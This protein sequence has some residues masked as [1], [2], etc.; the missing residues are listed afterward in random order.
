MTIWFYAQTDPYAEFSDFAPFGVEMA[1]AWWPTVEHSFQASKFADP[2]H[3]ERIRRAGPPTR[4]KAL[5]LGRDVPIR[6]DWDAARDGVMPDAL[7]VK[8]RPIRARATCCCPPAR[9]RSWRTRPTPTG[10]AVRTGRGSTAS[11]RSRCGSAAS[12]APPHSGQT[13]STAGTATA[14]TSASSGRPI[15]Q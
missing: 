15:R 9:R 13:S 14:I 4:A 3:R 1:G 5:G 6:P 8:F 10:A 11:A 12:C 2:A 7:R